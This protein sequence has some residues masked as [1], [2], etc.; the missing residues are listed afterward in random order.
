M[1]EKDELSVISEGRQAEFLLLQ[2]KPLLDIQVND[3]T[4]RMKAEF[5]TGKMTE[6]QM[7]SSIAQLCCL[8][9]FESALKR[10]ANN[11][12]RIEDKRRES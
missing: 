10:K 2:I 9:D 12:K 5:R 6:P 4:A 3:I 8:D 7:A 11:A 1:S